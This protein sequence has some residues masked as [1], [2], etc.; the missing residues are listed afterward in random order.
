MARSKKQA[1]SQK[2]VNVATIGMPTPVRKF[3]GNRLIALL[4]V[5]LLPVLYATGV[6]SIEWRD[7]R[8]RLS[9]DR[10]RA[11][12]VKMETA[13]K[14]HELR[15]EKSQNQGGRLSFLPQGEGG[16][17]TGEHGFRLPPAIGGQESQREQATRPLPPLKQLFNR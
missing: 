3:L 17:Q 16:Q 4:I 14:I 2:V 15:D 10:Q 13:E 12:E 5:L 6:V 7:G 9:F 1:I 11:A 8:P